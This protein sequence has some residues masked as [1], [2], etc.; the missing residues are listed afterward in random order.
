VAEKSLT[1]QQRE[2]EERRIHEEMVKKR[3][4][5]LRELEV[6]CCELAWLVALSA[7]SGLLSIS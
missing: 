1:K 3:Q 7:G 5:A 4:E 6:G 2:E